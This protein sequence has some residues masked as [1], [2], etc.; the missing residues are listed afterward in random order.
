MADESVFKL[1]L[2]AKEVNLRSL[3]KKYLAFA[4]AVEDS[5]VEECEQQYQSLLK[6]LAAYEFAMSKARSLVDTN[7]H[8]VVDYDHMHREV[9]A[10][11]CAPP[12]A[13][14]RTPR[15][16]ANRVPPCLQESHAWGHREAGC[17][18]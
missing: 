8:Q 7:N 10:E 14:T 17:A 2:L 18:A 3:T 6:E 16:H 11:M 4:Q 5:S 15:Q 13:S 12:L 9:E 1:R